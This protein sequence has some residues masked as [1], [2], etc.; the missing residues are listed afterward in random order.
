MGG[1]EV[2]LLIVKGWVVT[3]D[4]DNRVFRDGA[5]AVRGDR[6]VA[7]GPSEELREQYTA[8]RTIDARRKLIMPG[9]VDTYHHAGH[10]MVK[11]IHR[12]GVRGIGKLYFHGSTPDWWHA[13]GLLTAVERVKFGVTTGVTIMGG[14]PAR[15]DDPI[16]AERNAKAVEA[17]GTRSF[18][19]VGPPDLFV[20]HLRKRWSGTFFEDGEAVERPFTYEKTIE[21][22]REVFRRLKG[23]ANGRVQTMFAI[24]YLCGMNPRY[25]KGSHCYSYS[26]EEAAM[27]RDKA[28]EARQIADES[29]V[30]IHTHGA[31]G[32]FE[33]AEENYGPGVLREVLGPDVI[34]AHSNG[35][36]DRDIG[37]MRQTDCAASAVP[38]GAWN[39]YLGTCPIVKLIQNEVRVAIA[40]DGAAPFHISDLFIDLHRAMF[41]QWME[42]HDMSLLPSGRAVRLV[43]IEAA[44]LLGMEDEIGSLE[45]GKKADIIL[46]DLDQPHLVPFEDPANMIAWYVRGNDVDTVIVDGEVLMEGRRVVTVDEREVL[47]Y[48]SEEIN[49]SFELID[50]GP[51]LEH[52]PDFWQGWREVAQ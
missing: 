6:I 7:V 51:Y 1:E 2:D 42:N 24:P 46:V 33:W 47:E 11:G 41:L 49:K 28:L 30:L 4:G 25:M 43:T 3:V 31:R 37:I 21:V 23:A 44:A 27:M 38:F 15:T 36:T 20:D 13:E 19:A 10:G 52:N 12:Q 22:S 29:G 26:D 5:I 14:T 48:A 35:L 32:I 40:T 18:I 17:V 50:I 8:D 16:F 45:E 34:F 9:L 39:T